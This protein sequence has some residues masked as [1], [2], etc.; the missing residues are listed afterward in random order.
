MLPSEEG[1][2]GRPGPAMLQQST[3]PGFRSACKSLSDRGCT[4][5][6]ISPR[7]A[8]TLF[9]AENLCLK[10]LNS[11]ALNVDKPFSIPLVGK[12]TIRDQRPMTLPGRLVCPLGRTTSYPQEWDFS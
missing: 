2:L 8:G 3:S 1:I 10:S 6:V 4:P 5:H 9:V 12:P 7:K 11:Q